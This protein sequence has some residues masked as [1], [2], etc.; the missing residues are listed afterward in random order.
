MFLS[1]ILVV[2]LWRFLTSETEERLG[3]YVLWACCFVPTLYLASPAYR[4]GYGFAE[5]LAAFVLIPPIVLL[6]MRAIRYLL[7]SKVHHLRPYTRTVSPRSRMDRALYGSVKMLTFICLAY[8]MF[9]KNPILEQAS[10]ILAT[11]AVGF[12]LLSGLPFLFIR[13]TLC[14]PST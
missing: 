1:V 8:A 10:L 6:T 12:C 4:N 3:P 2:E 13:K 5:H 14:P 7:L 9:F 11:V